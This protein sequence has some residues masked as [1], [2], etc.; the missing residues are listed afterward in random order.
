MRHFQRGAKSIDQI[1][2]IKSDPKLDDEQ[3]KS[4]AEELQRIYELYD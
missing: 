2:E 1:S 4:L 3:I